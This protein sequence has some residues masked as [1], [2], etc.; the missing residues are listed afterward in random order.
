MTVF[1]DTIQKDAVG[2]TVGSV[3]TIGSITFNQA[4]RE[5]LGI[6]VQVAGTATKTA[7][8]ANLGK[9]LIQ[10]DDMG[11]STF[12]IVTN[13]RCGGAPGTNIEAE[14]VITQW[15]PYHAPIKPK[16]VIT[17]KYDALVPEPTEEVAVQITAVYSDG[18]VPSDIMD[19]ILKHLGLLPTLKQSKVT[20]DADIGDASSEALAETITIEGRY[21]EII[22]YRAVV[23]PDAAPTAGEIFLGYIEITGTVGNIS[24]QKWPLPAIGSSLGT[25]VGG[26][27]EAEVI[28]QTTF[29]RKSN[30]KDTFTMTANLLATT[31]GANGVAFSLI[32]R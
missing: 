13:R 8:E 9:L 16:N 31:T 26:A 23:S 5:L 3:E 27:V 4:A 11:I 15:I 25:P 18:D 10:S 20:V 22:G 2:T 24:P 17:F 28:E 12:E 6:L 21:K 30:A 19:A 32:A 7:A 1:A 29:F 14:K